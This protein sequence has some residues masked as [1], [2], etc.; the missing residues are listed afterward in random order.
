MKFSSATFHLVLNR[1]FLHEGQNNGK[2]SSTSGSPAFHGKKF[3]KAHLGPTFIGWFLH[4]FCFIYFFFS[5]KA[6]V[7]DKR[8]ERSEDQK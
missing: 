7:G 3:C 6:E 8:D 5:R 2:V 1:A 4:L